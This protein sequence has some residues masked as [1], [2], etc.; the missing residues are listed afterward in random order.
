MTLEMSL[1][2]TAELEPLTVWIR[3]FQLP[4]NNRWHKSD[5]LV[6]KY[7]GHKHKVVR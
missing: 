1:K 4:S 7:K 2:V 5:R 6:N 3:G